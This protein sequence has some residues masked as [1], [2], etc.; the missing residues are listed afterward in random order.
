MVMVVA[1]IA[2]MGLSLD[3]LAQGHGA[4][5]TLYLVGFMALLAC[6]L[7]SMGTMT[8]LSWRTRA[9]D[10]PTRDRHPAAPTRRGAAPTRRAWVD[11]PAQ[12]TGDVLWGTAGDVPPGMPW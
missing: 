4:S 3:W 5:L 9:A 1:F 12:Y 8:V 6:G 10:K 11:D 7:V 2:A